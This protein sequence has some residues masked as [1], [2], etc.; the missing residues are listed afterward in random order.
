MNTRANELRRIEL[1]AEKLMSGE[2]VFPDD[3]RALMLDMIDIVT[4][5]AAYRQQ[6]ERILALLGYKLNG[7]QVGHE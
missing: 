4:R 1:A 2:Y 6:C 5:R 3:K 7:G